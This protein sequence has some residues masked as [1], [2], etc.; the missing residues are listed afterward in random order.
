MTL[1][2]R[3]TME[4]HKNTLENTHKVLLFFFPR[5]LP[6]TYNLYPDT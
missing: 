2:K 5:R 4:T 3:T 6:I 1:F